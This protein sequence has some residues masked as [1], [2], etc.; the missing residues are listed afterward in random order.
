MTVQIGDQLPNVTLKQIT[1]DGF[2]DVNTESIFTGKTIALFAIPGAFTPICTTVH[3]P[4]FNEHLAQFKAK[5]VEVICLSVNDPF[6]LAAWAKD[7]NSSPDIG[8]LA[9]WNADFTNAIGLSFD[10]SGAGLGL[11]SKRYSM[12]VK[13]GI[14]ENLYIEESPGT[15]NLSSADNLLKAL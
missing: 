6:V 15:C 5:G 1:P 8:L 13:N 4:G 2:Q 12:L 7:T 14:V 9:D 11:R 10:G 3:L